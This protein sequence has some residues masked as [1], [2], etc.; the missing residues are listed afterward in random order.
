VGCGREGREARPAVEERRGGLEE[1]GAGSSFAAEAAVGAVAEAGSLT[2]RVGDLGRGLWK[3]W[4]AGAFGRGLLEGW[5]GLVVEG[6]EA[7]L[8]VEVEV[9]GL[10]AVAGVGFAAMEV[11][12]GSSVGVFVSFR[13]RC[14]GEPTLGEATLVGG[15]D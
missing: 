11:R 5:G 10:G 9:E 1:G 7:G 13:A 6:V 3:G 4:A 8:E 15:L 2:G 14:L 12:N